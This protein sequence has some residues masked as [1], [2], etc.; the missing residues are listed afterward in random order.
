MTV[1]NLPSS[2]VNYKC[3][4]LKYD[5]ARMTIIGQKIPEHRLED[6]S[7]FSIKTCTVSQVVKM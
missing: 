6:L 7:K 2:P 3:V 5:E 1:H 4:D